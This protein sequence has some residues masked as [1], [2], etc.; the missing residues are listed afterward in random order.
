[1]EHKD[2]ISILQKKLL[3]LQAEK[4]YLKNRNRRQNLF[5]YGIEKWETQKYG[6]NPR[7]RLKKSL[8]TSFALK[9]YRYK[10]HNALPYTENKK[11]DPLSQISLSTK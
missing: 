3:S 7:N 1:M 8:V 6:T 11:S 2:G 5:F 4:V 9:W 10:G